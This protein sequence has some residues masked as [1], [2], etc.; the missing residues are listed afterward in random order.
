MEPSNTYLIWMAGSV[1]IAAGVHCL[2]SSSLRRRG[3]N[4][5]LTALLGLALGVACAKAVYAIIEC[6]QFWMAT[7]LK[8][9]RPLDALLS[10]D[11][12]RASFFG[13]VLGVCLGAALAGKL[14]GNA[15]MKALNAYAPAGMLMAALA[16][17]G[18]GF[19]GTLGLGRVIENESLCFFPLAVVNRWGQGRWAV[20]MLMG[21]ACLIVGVL[22]LLRFRE[23]RFLR[24]LFYLCLPQILLESLRD[25]CLVVHEFVRVEQ[26][27]CM[28]T[29]EVIFI[30]YG[31][32]ARGWKRRFLPAAMGL[33]CAGI[34]VAVEFTLGGKL[35]NGG[36]VEWDVE[37]GFL[38][39][40]LAEEE[41][42]LEE[43][44][45][46][47]NLVPFLA[48][49]VMALGLMLLAWMETLGHRHIRDGIGK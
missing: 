25:E 36:G 41:E 5:L 49:C 20:F 48:Y 4:A 42:W 47:V 19:L 6:L 30:L 39:H 10:Y 9:F 2:I 11:V 31:V 22:S 13:G 15:P 33:V 16:R 7:G 3:M 17:F 46:G 21:V 24:T 18:E 8:N 35:F 38:R 43:S 34:F 32:W 29:V 37:E 23:N 40:A 27:I 28:V 44:G 26:L 14:T 45:G 1:L 12:Y